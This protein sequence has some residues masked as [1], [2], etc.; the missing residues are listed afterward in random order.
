MSSALIQ[1]EIWTKRDRKTEKLVAKP[2]KDKKGWVMYRTKSRQSIMHLFV[3]IS[4]CCLSLKLS[5]ITISNG[6]RQRQWKI[7][8]V[9]AISFRLIRLK[10]KQTPQFFSTLYFRLGKQNCSV[11]YPNIFLATWKI[12][13][14]ERRME[15]KKKQVKT[16]HWEWAKKAKKV[17]TKTKKMQKDHRFLE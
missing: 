7:L 6:K 10:Y 4:I 11:C 16:K 14:R 9:N 12:F 1:L 3:S 8:F 13:G 17:N 2:T 5:S 15:R